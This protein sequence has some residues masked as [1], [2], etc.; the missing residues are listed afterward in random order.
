VTSNLSHHRQGRSVPLEGHLKA[1]GVEVSELASP[2]GQLVR[3]K[4]R[5]SD[6]TSDL[7]E[8]VRLMLAGPDAGP[9]YRF[10]GREGERVTHENEIEKA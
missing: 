6:R 5:N 8:V 4:G 2:P 3:T 10:K 7:Y 1:L 9:Q